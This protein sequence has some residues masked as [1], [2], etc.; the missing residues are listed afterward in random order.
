MES[1]L[2]DSWA[3]SFKFPYYILINSLSKVYGKYPWTSM[4]L[5]RWGGVPFITGFETLR[6][7]VGSCEW[8]GVCRALLWNSF[9]SEFASNIGFPLASHDF[10]FTSSQISLNSAQMFVVLG[11]LVPFLFAFMHN[12]CALLHLA[13]GHSWQIFIHGIECLQDMMR[14][15]CQVAVMF[16]VDA[17]GL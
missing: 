6:S 13:F 3:N 15:H 7:P 12:P 5:L 14:I 16:G 9:G 2:G 1:A 11:V 8:H 10:C 4:D 17:T